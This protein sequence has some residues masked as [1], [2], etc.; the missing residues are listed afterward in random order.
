MR[1]PIPKFLSVDKCCLV[2]NDINDDEGVVR[3]MALDP[4]AG[5][6]G[7]YSVIELDLRSGQA[8]CIGRELPKKHAKK[9]VKLGLSVMHYIE[10]QKN[11]NG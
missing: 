10:G 2:M 5:L 1:L 7:R 4:A 11:L 8:I 9:I 3:F 6:P